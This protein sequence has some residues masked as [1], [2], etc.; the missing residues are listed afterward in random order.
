MREILVRNHLIQGR[1]K[2]R[3]TI[4]AGSGRIMD[5]ALGTSPMQWMAAMPAGEFSESISANISPWPRNERSPLVGLKSA[6]YA[7]NLIALDHARQMGFEET[8]LINTV[9]QLCETATANLF[10]VKDGVL[11]TPSLES[12]CLPG[13]PRHCRKRR[14]CWATAR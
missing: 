8:I 11:L 6:S 13:I 9:G 2:I 5:L 14:S 1:A 4:T 12:G 7:E 10:L 3:L